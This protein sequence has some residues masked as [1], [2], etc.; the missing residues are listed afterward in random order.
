MAEL[1]RQIS[2]VA[3]GWTAA[4]TPAGHDRLLGTDPE[5]VAELAIWRAGQHIPESDHRPTG[6]NRY[7]AVERAHQQQLHRRI[8]EL[9]GNTGLPQHRWAATVD[10][11][12]PRISA[13]PTWPIIATNID[14]AARVG[15]DIETQLTDA[16]VARPLPDEMPAAALWARLEIA[17]T[18]LNGPEPDQ[19]SATEP[20]PSDAVGPGDEADPIGSVIASAIDAATPSGCTESTCEVNGIEEFDPYGHQER[21][22]GH[23]IDW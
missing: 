20:L 23:G 5:L 6:P 8:L 4:T 1:A 19:Y 12:D 10:R 21:D 11:I 2:D 7:T 13:D 18:D 17:D 3:R 14:A 9:D 16:V 22:V 15:L